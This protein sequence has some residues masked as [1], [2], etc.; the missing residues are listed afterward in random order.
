[1]AEKEM[2]IATKAFEL[3]TGKHISADIKT[4]VAKSI[5][6]SNIIDEAL[7]KYSETHDERQTFELN[8]LIVYHQLQKFTA[9]AR[10]LALST[11]QNSLD[12]PN[13]L[14]EAAEMEE[15]AHRLEKEKDGQAKK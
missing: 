4:A 10:Q 3:Y 2:Q 6:L 5:E 15:L 8:S 1:M 14:K 9:E 13:E 7:A 12:N 11:I